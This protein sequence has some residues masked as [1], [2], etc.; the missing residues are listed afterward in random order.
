ML[1]TTIRPHEE[2]SVVRGIVCK[3]PPADVELNTTFFSRQFPS[4]VLGACRQRGDVAGQVR[5]A[6]H[7]HVP[8]PESERLYAPQMKA[9]SRCRD[10]SI[11]QRCAVE[12]RR[13][14]SIYINHSIEV[15][16]R[17]VDLHGASIQHLALSLCFRMKTAFFLFDL[18]E[19][20][21]GDGKAHLFELSYTVSGT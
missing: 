3:L 14:H 12:R 4:R 18:A 7:M 19:R 2:S 6:F 11:N 17:R 1:L 21:Q 8:L 5:S 9:A 10:I 16:R 13:V 20:M 15:V